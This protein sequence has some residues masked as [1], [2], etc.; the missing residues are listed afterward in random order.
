MIDTDR[1]EGHT[2]APW[3]ATHDTLENEMGWVIN[4][5]G[6]RVWVGEKDSDAPH[7]QNNQFGSESLSEADAQLIADAPLLLAEV[8]RLQK[9]S[10]KLE[11]AL[12]TLADGA[13]DVPMFNKG[14]EAYE[15][16]WGDGE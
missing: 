11:N 7:L 16:L 14:G 5:D 1:Y 3:L 10:K 12:L 2:P 13:G 9:R 15:A 4:H 8:K 6:W